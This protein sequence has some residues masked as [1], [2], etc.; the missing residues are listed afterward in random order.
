M[1]EAPVKPK[2]IGR[3]WVRIELLETGHYDMQSFREGDKMQTDLAPIEDSE[4]GIEE[5]IKQAGYIANMYVQLFKT[6]L[7]M[8]ENIA[9]IMEFV[10]RMTPMVDIWE[11]I[12]IVKAVNGIEPPEAATEQDIPRP[13]SI[14]LKKG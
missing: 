6:A 3:S 13:E 1:K 2:V 8:F 11:R 9:G 12:Q 14:K 5:G 10:G 7:V 4:I